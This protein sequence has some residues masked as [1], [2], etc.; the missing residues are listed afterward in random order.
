MR[1]W[2]CSGGPPEGDSLPIPARGSPAAS[3][4]VNSN[5]CTP[6]WLHLM[7]QSDS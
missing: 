6:D 5:L 1:W 7:Y 3:A 4:T 2:C